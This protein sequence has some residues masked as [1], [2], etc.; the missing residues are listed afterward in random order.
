MVHLF[1]WLFLEVVVTTMVGLLETGERCFLREPARLFCFFR[2]NF[3]ALSNT[4]DRFCC[5]KAEHS[6]YISAPIFLANLMP[7]IKLT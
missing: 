2:H 1:D 6:T 7:W 3:R 4:V 5:D